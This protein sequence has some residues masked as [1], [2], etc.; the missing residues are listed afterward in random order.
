MFESCLEIRRQFSEY[1]D[2][3]CSD[4]ARHSIRYHLR[5]CAG[6]ELELDRYQ[7][8]RSDLRSL[9]RPRMSV[10]ARL[11]LEVALSQARHPYTLANL[12]VRL[13]NV[14]RPLLLPASG[15]VLAGVLCLGL[16]LDWLIIPPAAR[17]E[18]S[19]ATPAAVEAL[20]PVDFNTGKDG[21][22]L[23]T[24]VN[25]DGRVVD[26]EVVSG[27]AS[28]ELKSHLDQLM[29]FSVF[30]PATRL[31]KPIDGQ[32]ILSLR[33]ITVRGWEPARDENSKSPPRIPEPTES[34]ERARV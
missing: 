27:N 7:L 20:E 4:D 8:L 11:Q 22:C 5:T 12:G 33:R 26:Y 32:V 18:A 21:L 1:V 13:E 15:A 28:P 2:E 34:A 25:A 16:T 9:P 23:I 24:H 19:L 3:D 30:R 6:C 17:P 14:L 31:G 29:Y 10:A